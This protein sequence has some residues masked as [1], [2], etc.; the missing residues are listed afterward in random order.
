MGATLLRLYRC[1]RIAWRAL[2]AATAPRKLALQFFLQATVGI[3]VLAM[4]VP[5]FENPDE[6]NHMNRVDE[7]ANGGFVARRYDGPLTSGGNVDT[8]INRIDAMIGG[9][10]FHPERKVTRAM[11]LNA[12]A[13]QWGHRMP[14]TFA[15]TSIYSPFLYLPAVIGD[16]AGKLF[17]FSIARTLILSRAATG[18]ACAAV[19]AAA[20]ALAGEAAMYLFIVLSLPMSLFLFASV[21]QDG[22]MLALAA[23][24]IALA[25]CIQNESPAARPARFVA[26][27]ACVCLLGI[28]RPAYAPFC[29]LP[30]LLTGIAWRQRVA[31]AALAVAGIAAWSLI[32]AHWSLINAVGS[33]GV[34]P[35]AQMRA[36][37]MHP[38]L[39]GTLAHS[40]VTGAQGMEGSSFFRET[41]GILGWQDVFLPDWFYIVAG[42]AWLGSVIVI[43]PRDRP[44]LPPGAQGALF[45][46]G[47]AA[48]VLVFLLEYLTWT[49]VGLP[50]V[51]G[52]QGRY[53]LPIALFL[54]G[55]LPN[56]R[57]AAAAR[58]CV[59]ARI[60]LLG[61]PAL[62]IAV[63]VS[64]VVRRYYV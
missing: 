45:I 46:A 17:G 32:A 27:C 52:V 29:V 1:A 6:F 7:I 55:M 30:L 24:A 57:S 12:N 41:V 25:L 34:D 10:R 13:V 40:V 19:A 37:L 21:S 39:W 49:P 11:M 62:S 26:V 63:M 5:P 60:L 18:I 61:F 36:L 38:T 50:V 53:F 16:R 35:P 9:I 23:M 58:I 3:L 14:A 22:P 42:C 59:P 31:G 8:G 20:I 2:A 4:L 28:G 54:P 43:L 51:Q 44:G 48:V 56:L 64:C 47:A 33:I 15:N